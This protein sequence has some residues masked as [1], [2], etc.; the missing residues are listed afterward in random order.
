LDEV[1]ADFTYESKL[2]K[3]ERIML[4]A[5]KKFA[6]QAMEKKGGAPFTRVFFRPSGMHV[7]VRYYVLAKDRQ[8]VMSRITREIYS[9]V[10][11][12]RDVEFA[13]PHTEVILRRGAGGK[14]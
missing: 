3:V 11:G 1:G 9:R 14:S 2:P 4:E 6:G 12:Q 8:E 7:R 5:S 10:M 13:Y